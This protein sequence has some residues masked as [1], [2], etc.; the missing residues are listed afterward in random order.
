MNIEE[1]KDYINFQIDYYKT[2][3]KE[4]EESGEEGNEYWA[5]Y[6]HSINLLEDIRF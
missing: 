6:H 3:I 4:C 2:L 1:L 5:Q